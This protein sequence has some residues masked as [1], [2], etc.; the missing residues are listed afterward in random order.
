M[1]ALKF[2]QTKAFMSKLLLS[3]TF[4]RFLLVEAAIT[5]GVTVSIDGTFHRDFY[6]KE[7]L[8]E[9][10]YADASLIYWEHLRPVCLELIKGKKT[11]LG[12]KFV[13]RLS[14]SNTEKLLLQAGL[15]Y[16]PSDVKG[17]YLNLRYDQ[18][19]LTC[20]TATALSKFTLNKSLD[21]AWDSM[22]RKFFLRQE[23]VFEEL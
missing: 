4:D 2:S 1:L 6:T 3:S 8:S 16:A 14:S 10:E 12:F 21:E 20:T 18:G 11:P 19:T 13:F 15:P 22:V 9:K 7:E 23:L 17:L 5:T